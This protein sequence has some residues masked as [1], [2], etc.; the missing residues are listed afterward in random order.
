MFGGTC[1]GRL[2]PGWEG[3]D[4]GAEGLLGGQWGCSSAQGGVA[5]KRE[6][7][8]GSRGSGEAGFALTSRRGGGSVP[9]R[10]RHGRLSAFRVLSELRSTCQFTFLSNICFAFHSSRHKHA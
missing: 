6:G 3:W 4:G 9:K 5:W 2:R 10:R 1:E 8:S 7:A